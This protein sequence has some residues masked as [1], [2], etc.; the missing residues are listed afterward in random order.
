MA[1]TLKQ[2]VAQV[3]KENT[4]G[5][6]TADAQKYVLGLLRYYAKWGAVS[7]GQDDKYFTALDTF[8]Y[9]MYT[10]QRLGLLNNVHILTPEEQDQQ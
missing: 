4:R 3:F 5:G 9:Q 2:A 7:S 6:D 1:A 8:D 10:M